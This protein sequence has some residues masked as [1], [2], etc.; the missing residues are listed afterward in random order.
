MSQAFKLE[1]GLSKHDHVGKQAAYRA[2]DHGEDDSGGF[3]VFYRSQGD[4]NNCPKNRANHCGYF[5]IQQAMEVIQE[6]DNEGGK[7]ACP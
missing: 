1:I 3:S 7:G 6:T 4:R 5:D 2:I